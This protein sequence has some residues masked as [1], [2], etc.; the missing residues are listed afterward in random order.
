MRD[1]KALLLVMV[2]LIADMSALASAE[3]VSTEETVVEADDRM[4]LRGKRMAS[5]DYGWWFSYGPDSNFNGMDDRLEKVMAGQESV[6]STAIIGADGLKTVAIVVD[7]AWHPGQDEIDE[8]VAVLRSH[9]WEADGSWF[10]VMDSIDSIVVDHVP[11]S[12]LV[13]ILALESVVVI[14]MQNLMDMHLE[15]ANPATRI[16]PSDVYSGTVYDRGYTGEN[17]VIAVLDSGV[18]NEHRSLND[19]DDQNDAPDL[20]ANSY[21]D[22]KWVG[23]YDATSQASNPDGSQD[24]DDGQGHGTHVAGIALGTGDSS[25]VHVGGAPGAFLV[26]VKVLTDSGGTNSQNSLNGIQWMINNKDTDWGNGAKGI[27]IGQM[28]FGSIG[29]PLNPDDTGDNGSGA[30]SRL[31]NNATYDHG[32]ACIVAA[33]NDGKQRIASPGSA[34]GAI[35]IGSADNSDTINRTD[36]FMASYSNSGPRDTDNDD[37]DWDELK[38]D[39]TA[40]GS[41]IYSASAATGTSLPGTPRPEADNS[42]ESKD[43]TSMATPLV[44]GV[45]ALMLQANP[46]L[47]PVEI[48]DILRN[49]SEER[50]GASE[51]SVSERWNNEWG[52]GLLDASCAVDMAL[53]RSCTPLNG[54]GG[55]VVL[56]PDNSTAEGVEIESLNNGTWFVAGDITRI[57][58]SVIANSG[59]WDDVDIRITQYYEEDDEVVLLDWTTAGGDIDS[60]YLDVLIKDEWFDLDE[61]IVVIE[62][63][64]MGDGDLV[65]SDVRW[66]YIGRMSV[67]FGSPSSGSVLSDT[68]TFTGTGQGV[69]PSNLMF[70]VDS[71]EWEEVH[72]FDD[73]DNYTQD[74]SFTWNSN[75]VGDGS[76]KISIKLVNVS[77]DESDVVRRTFTIDNLPAAP[78]LRFQGTVQIYDQDLPAESAV[79]GTILEVHFSVVN[80]GDADA[81][82]LHLKLDAPGSESSTYPSEGKLPR[83]DQGETISV[84]LWWWA[85]E[86]GIHDVTIQIDPNEAM[87]D[88]QSDNDYTF[89]FEIEERPVEPTLRFPTSAITTSSPIPSPTLDADSPKPYTITVRV[90]NMGQTDATNVKMTLSTWDD[91]CTANTCW[92]VGDTRTISIIPGSTSSSGNG[93]AQFTH[94]HDSVGVV[95]HKILLEGNGVEDQYSELRFTVIV[96]EYDI[97]AKTGLTISE[98]ES[99]IGFVGIPDSV[100]GEDGGGLLFTTIDGELHARTLTA[101][102]GMPGDTL[103]ERNWAGEFAFVLRD[104][105]R[106]HLAWTKRFDDQQGYTMADIGMASIG[107]LG[108]VSTSTSH[109]TPLKQSEGN[110]WGLDL[111]IRGDEIVLAG[112]HRDISTGGSWNDITNIFMIHNDDAKSSNG[113]TTRMNVLTDVDIKPQDGDSIAVAIGQDDIH[114]LYQSMRDDVTGIERVG[115]FYAHGVISQT[116]FNFQAPAGDDA[117]I[118]EM[119][120]VEDGDDDILVAAWIEG[121]GRSSKLISVVQNTIWSIDEVQNISSPGATNIIMMRTTE[122]DI[123]IYHDEIGV[124]GPVTRYGMYTLGDDKIGL[125]NLIAEGHVIGAGSIGDD[126]IVIMTSPSGQISA[127]KVAYGN[128][129]GDDGAD[130]SILEY[131][132]SPLPGDTQEEKL[133][134]LAMIGGFLIVLFGSVLV[135]LKRS[136]RQE[137]EIEVSAESGDLEL[138]I[139]TEE[140]DGAL[141]AINTDGSDELVISISQPKVVL[142]DELEYETPDLSSELEAKVEAGIASKRLERRMKRKGDRE[143]KEKFD[144]ISK[145]LPPIPLPGTINDKPLPI[146]VDLPPLPMPPAPGELPLPELGKLPPLPL[147]TSGKLPPLPLPAMPAPERKVT[148]GSCGAGITVKDMTLRKMDCPICSEIIQM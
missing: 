126:S 5:E 100:E 113:W 105:N 49:S 123:K 63:N 146:L 40:Y 135:I 147:P 42:Y 26:D 71:G 46:D 62:A 95:K 16:L 92:L 129:G 28:S 36:D 54:G 67:S 14:E 34:D 8:L 13:E 32:I 134:S 102:F 145:N 51:S 81:I 127:K 136:H 101:R 1:V 104:D 84:I 143:A 77:G 97:G 89:S 23:G 87:N 94:I 108:D 137:D 11:V 131:L 128:P 19:F 109:L 9:G 144:E 10:Q 75:E 41:G 17:V 33:G 107:L 90:D 20:D 88:D 91:D 148:C 24:P 80:T 2:F 120:V 82:D 112:Y 7:F 50:G 117:S 74:W 116:P 38:P 18:D 99:V 31:V 22:Q 35:T 122:E 96:D 25:A 39:I 61:T 21:D 12:S 141:I 4:P 125:S 121:N 93:K 48:K 86:A 98:G 118:P 64:A 132:L 57:S 73:T 15:S 29:T 106:V 55:G 69:E 79:A 72:T 58:G 47:T 133:T 130:P 45:V 56:P 110:Y 140:D 43:G 138:L 83:V 139:E 78:E 52:F 37:D 59:P 119:L 111:S 70:R 76:H 85:T 103:I 66:G 68:V 60:W 44:S 3:P 65:S 6:S 30:E 53:E 142:D 27:D 114:I 115:L 124:L